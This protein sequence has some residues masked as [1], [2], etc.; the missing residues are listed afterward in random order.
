[1][2]LSVHQR[3]FCTSLSALAEPSRAS[4]KRVSAPFAHTSPT[5]EPGHSA[6]LAPRTRKPRLRVATPLSTENALG[7]WPWMSPSKSMPWR[8][9]QA[10]VVPKSKRGEAADCRSV[11]EGRQVAVGAPEEG[12]AARGGEGLRPPPA[13]VCEG[14]ASPCEGHRGVSSCAGRPLIGAYRTSNKF[15]YSLP[16][17]ANSCPSRYLNS[18]PQAT[19][20]L[21]QPRS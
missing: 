11:R 21:C 17:L 3:G 7:L 8:L 18:Q 19:A 13:C 1:M 6:R 20:C 16:I 2:P 14:R 12:P 10:S 5:R 9:I 4:E 15:I